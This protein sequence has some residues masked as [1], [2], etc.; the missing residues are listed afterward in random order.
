MANTIRVKRRASGAAGAPAV[1]ENAELAFNEVDN[2]LWY[3]KGTGGANGTAT[4]IIAIGGDGAYLNLSGTQTITGT[5]TFTGEVD[6][7]GATV[8][9]FTT[10]GGVVIGGDLTVN[11]TTTTINSVTVSS[12]DKNIELGATETPT[13]AGADSGGITLKGTTDKTI[14]WLDA[15]DA[16]TFSE[17]V[18][19][20]AGK[21]YYIN[22]TA[23]LS[24]TA[25]GSGVTGSSLTSVGTLH[26]GIWQAGVIGTSY[27][28]TGQSSY[29]DGE[30][31][32]GTS[33][34]GGL[35]KATLTGGDG[36]TVT[37]GNGS[38]T[39]SADLKT[40]GGLVIESGQVAVD[41]GASAIT[42][43]LAIG[44]GGTGATDA[45]TARANLGL[46]LGS[47]AQAWDADLDTLSGMQTG[48]AA[49]V[50]A[51]TATEVAVIDG[52]TAATATTL[53][54]SDRMVINDA[55]SMVQVALSDLIT[56]LENGAVSG[57][58]ID[59]GTY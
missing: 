19:L 6:L 23:V 11:G 27:G 56:F 28:G 57:F 46:A 20:A 29:L 43:T 39:I 33:T 37:N 50:A 49:A 35:A 59:G 30:I 8:S 3:G 54:L 13:D 40:N 45:S 7:S 4:N 58:D 53:A 44:D 17:H 31:L 15:T 41:L 26:A 34:T 12:E 51:L 18:D 24:A 16:W 47:D 10:T 25:L 14:N 5:K 55:G 9:G 22:G 36:M 38:I 1:L 48:A 32:I 21:S 42:G 2:V 52:S